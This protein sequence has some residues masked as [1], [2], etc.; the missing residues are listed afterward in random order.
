MTITY[1]PA[2]AATDADAQTLTAYLDRARERDSASTVPAREPAGSADAALFEAVTAQAQ[3]ARAVVSN[4]ATVSGMSETAAE[5]TE[6]APA[7]RT[8]CWAATPTAEREAPHAATAPGPVPSVSMPDALGR[9]AVDPS[10]WL[11]GQLH[12]FSNG[13][14]VDPYAE[15]MLRRAGFAPARR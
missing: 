13:D 9:V 6:L 2:P 1:A 10:V 7:S 3:A 14:E 15:L 8:A 4:V 12:R 5:D 11:A